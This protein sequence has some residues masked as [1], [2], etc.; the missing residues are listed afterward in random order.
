MREAREGS[1]TSW[2]RPVRLHMVGETRKTQQLEQL[3]KSYRDG[4]KLPKFDRGRSSH[5]RRAP[6]KEEGLLKDTPYLHAADLPGH[7]IQ[8]EFLPTQLKT[9]KTQSTFSDKQLTQVSQPRVF[10]YAIRLSNKTLP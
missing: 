1:A 6:N 5:L 3:I 8:S 9:K 7:S 2:Q 10:F 4:P